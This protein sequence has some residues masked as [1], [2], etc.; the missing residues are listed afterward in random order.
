MTIATLRAP[1]LSRYARGVDED[2]PRDVIGD[3]TPSAPPIT[4]TPSTR[5]PK[6]RRAA[7]LG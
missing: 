6:R 3:A 2:W 4:T 5:A 7:D 1:S